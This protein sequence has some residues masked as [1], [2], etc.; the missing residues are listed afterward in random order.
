MW[1]FIVAGAGPFVAPGVFATVTSVEVE[2]PCH[3]GLLGS[4]AIVTTRH[5]FDESTISQI[6]KLLT[7][8]GFDVLVS[9][10]EIAKVLLKS[11]NFFKSEFALA[12]RIHAFHDIE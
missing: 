2:K 9:G 8:L 3:A 10:I 12:Q 5:E 1:A 11:I 4:Q 7:Y 6:L